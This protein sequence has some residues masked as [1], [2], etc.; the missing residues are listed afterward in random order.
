MKNKNIIAVRNLIQCLD[1]ESLRNPKVVANLVR[2]F[3]IM[4][5]GPKT[6]GP[7][8]VFINKDDGG[9]CIGQ[10]PD[11]IAG[12]LVY[13]SRFKI[14]SFCEIGVMYG[15]NFL[16]C[17][18]YLRRFNPDIQCLGIDPTGY[19]EAEI[20]E[21]IDR[22]LHLN[23]KAV[24][25]DGIAGMVFDFAFLDADHST[26]WIIKDWENVGRH[27]KICG[28][29]DLQDALWP[30]VAAFWETLDNPKKEKV[31]FLDDPS[32]CRVHGIGIIHDKGAA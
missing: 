26:P 14:K 13:L 1:L 12:A 5:W 22:E 30:D 16:F 3:G 25:S 28:F 8:T 32:G 20:K 18:E 11:Q 15:G 9:A 31:E 23:F 4:P 29:H 21:I 19:L 17:S 2:A 24:T 10:T 6:S 27:A 7:E